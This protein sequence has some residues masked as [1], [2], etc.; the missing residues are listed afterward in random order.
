MRNRPEVIILD[1]DNT[2]YF[3][4]PCH[5]AGTQAVENEAANR[6]K[7]D[8]KEWL[9]HFEA[10]REEVK[11]QLGDVA[12]SHS[13]LIYFKRT[14]ENLGLQNHLDLAFQL[15]TIYWGTFLRTM[16]KAPDVD[17]FLEAAREFAIPVVVATDLTTGIQIRKIHQLR[18]HDF[19]AGLVTSEEV[20]CDK[21][22]AE[23]ISR[24][25]KLLTDTPSNWL[26]IG[27]D[28]RKDGGLAKQVPASEFFHVNL[29]NEP[30]RHFKTLTTS[31]RKVCK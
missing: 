20:G 18:I 13:R 5:R 30:A 21:P 15:E 22:G 31:L 3:Y 8:R 14:L 7:V 10:S 17:E 27:D 25:Q 6:L 16:K 24:I 23:F 2:V 1:L 9:K 4:P 26:F 28:K 11:V 12:A 29:V 19:L